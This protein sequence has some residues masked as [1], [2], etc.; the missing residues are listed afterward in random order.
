MLYI[1]KVTLGISKLNKL[2]EETHPLHRKLYLQ[3]GT[4]LTNM[5]T[6]VLTLQAI[7]H[8]LLSSPGGGEA[9]SSVLH[10]TSTNI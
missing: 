8:P 4:Q 1:Q 5:C 6:D 10:C 9:K 3:Y 7:P 2:I